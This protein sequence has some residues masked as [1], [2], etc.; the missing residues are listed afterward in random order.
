MICYF[1]YTDMKDSWVPVTLEKLDEEHRK[2]TLR[3][4][5]LGLPAAGGLASPGELLELR[6]GA[7]SALRSVLG[8]QTDWMLQQLSKSLQEKLVQ[9]LKDSTLPFSSAHC[10]VRPWYGM[11]EIPMESCEAVLQ[12]LRAEI[13]E[14][15]TRANNCDS[16][17]SDSTIL[18]WLRTALQR[19]ESEFK[20]SRFPALEIELIKEAY[21]HWQKCWK[22][23]SD[24]VPRVLNSLLTATGSAV[25][26]TVN[27]S[28]LT[29]C[30]DIDTDRVI[31]TIV[32]LY[33]G[34]RIKFLKNELSRCAAVSVNVI[35]RDTV[36]D[37][38]AERA[39]ILQ[40]IQRV[41]E[42]RD[43]IEAIAC[44]VVRLPNIST[45]R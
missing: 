9:P 32:Q 40:K 20:L 38:V 18:G 14:I 13:H 41:D 8:K 2:L 12:E 43:G 22:S 1:V 25:R 26:L 37:C 16:T 31:G 21:G 28:K 42:A 4:L 5:D 45:H 23:F 6:H 29:T 34:P 44:S 11:R 15:C 27:S 3:N 36:E 19:D 39:Q 24:G 17:M 10:G 35:A 7:E 30:V 33:G